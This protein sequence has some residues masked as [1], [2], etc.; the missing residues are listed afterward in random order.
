MA[1]GLLTGK[2]TRE[3]IENV[4]SDDWSRN[5]ENFREPELS[6][7]LNL[8]EKLREIGAHHDASPTEVAIA[9]T[10]RHP[11]VSAAIVGGR[12]PD[13]VDGVVGAADLE[14]SDEELQEIEAFLGEHQ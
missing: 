3:R 12:R 11:A 10:L 14:L 7:N 5:A 2:M 1:S 9:W 13:Q 6:R 8:V 4:P